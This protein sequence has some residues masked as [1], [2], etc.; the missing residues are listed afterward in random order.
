MFDVHL[1]SYVTTRGYM[2]SD[3][4]GHIVDTLEDKQQE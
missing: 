3:V 2:V 1:L 4:R